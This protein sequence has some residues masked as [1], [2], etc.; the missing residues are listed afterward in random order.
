MEEGTNPLVDFYKVEFLLSNPTDAPLV[1]NLFNTNV[2]TT[3]PAS[4]NPGIFPNAN[5][6]NI[7]LGSVSQGS[8]YC[9]Q[10][11]TLFVT[12]TVGAGPGT[13]NR[14]F[15]LNDQNEILQNLD[16]GVALT[17]IA[18]N[19]LNNSMYGIAQ[20]TSNDCIVI[21][22]DTFAV[23]FIPLGVVAF[24]DQGWRRILYVAS[25]NKMF[26]SHSAGF[27]V[28][29]CTTNVRTTATTIFPPGTG[30]TDLAYSPTSNSVLMTMP[31]I[32]RA[33]IIN[34]TT[35]VFLGFVFGGSVNRP[36]TVQY[37][38]EVDEFYMFMDNGVNRQL[39]RI[40]GTTLVQIGLLPTILVGD[41]SAMSY[42]PATNHLFMLMSENNRF[43]VLDCAT[44]LYVSN[45]LSSIAGIGLNSSTTFNPNTNSVYFTANAGLVNVIGQIVST[46]A[47]LFVTGSTDINEF[48][49]DALVN[50]KEI[51][52][53][54]IYSQSNTAL[55]NPLNINS[56]DAD[57]N[58]CDVVKLP[59][60]QLATNQLQNGIA[61]INF[62]KGLMLNSNL[63]F[64]YT[65]NAFSDVAFIV[66]YKEI[67]RVDYIQDD[68][69]EVFDA[70][71]LADPNV[72]TESELD[73]T[74]V[75][76]TY[77]QK[78][79][80]NKRI[81]RLEKTKKINKQYQRI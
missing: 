55:L 57:G 3:L 50:P 74:K 49:E 17:S 70:T 5:G 75:V 81:K 37:A 35:D 9:T 62:E 78:N 26:I 59:N 23:S 58:S 46:P 77:E 24:P 56:L 4:N 44:N 13:A 28:V 61:Q 31:T 21:N 30:N 8:A 72:Y 19:S 73:E 64:N 32:D 79:R 76:P 27:A 20:G 6:T 71:Y 65:V 15:V 39:L 66:Y 40:N 22:C 52:R 2:L 11:K 14:L 10:N 42:S 36:T 60:V 18:Y 45:F 7:S 54:T 68:T 80:T 48:T 51:E 33:A 16:I 34:A 53:V 1:F 25:E 43:R 47:R 63:N 69:E 38:S 67:R 12:T 41:C 29:D